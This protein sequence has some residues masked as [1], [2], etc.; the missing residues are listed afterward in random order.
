[1]DRLAE[2]HRER[3]E[4]RRL[5]ALECARHV[6][7]GA[8]RDGVHVSLIGSLAKASF[9]L[10]SDVDFFVHD[11]VDPTGRVRV[12]RLVASA[13]KGTGLPYDIVYRSDLTD[14]RAREF[15]NA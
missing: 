10:H 12:E 9:R 14:E 13:F 4:R 11:A 3:T 6:L 1:M 15:L 7:E 8:E 5:V 2:I